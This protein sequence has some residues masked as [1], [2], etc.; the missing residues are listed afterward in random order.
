MG[1]SVSPWA[2]AEAEA[3]ADRYNTSKQ[4][5]AVAAT[6]AAAAAADVVEVEAAE[7]EA[8]E[9]AAARAKVGRC[10]LS[11]SKPELKASLV[12]ALE[13]KK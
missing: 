12:S 10:R 8:V 11:V 1:T 5:G 3:A 4:S 6:A 9:A 7:V 13:T 2:E